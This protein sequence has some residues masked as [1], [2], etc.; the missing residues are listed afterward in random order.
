MWFVIIIEQLFL[1]ML[2]YGYDSAD[3]L[4]LGCK[5]E[6][7]YQ[8]YFNGTYTPYCYNYFRIVAWCWKKL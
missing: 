2:F 4:T 1:F 7:F 8:L 6:S 5:L 3:D